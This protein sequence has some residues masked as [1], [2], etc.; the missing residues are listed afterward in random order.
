ME[1]FQQK[2]LDVL[3]PLFRL[4]KG[5]EDS[6]NSPN[7]TVPV[8]V[9]YHI[10]LTELLLGHGLISILHSLRLQILKALIKDPKKAKNIFKKKADLLQK[11]N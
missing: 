2:L 3:G 4:W 5:L 1:K 10:K 7:D 9:E 11:G 8:P 6:K